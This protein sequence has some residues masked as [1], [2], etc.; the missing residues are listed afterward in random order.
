MLVEKM[1]I[2]QGEE[3]SAIKSFSRASAPVHSTGVSLDRFANPQ[4][5]ADPGYRD[6]KG[7]QLIGSAC[8]RDDDMESLDD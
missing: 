1:P 3:D 6:V 5:S 7:S 8:A 2:L 4:H